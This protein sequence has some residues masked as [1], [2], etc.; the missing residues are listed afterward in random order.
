MV[1]HMVVV[2]RVPGVAHERFQ[3]VGEAE[4]EHG[5]V[6]RQHAVVV[7]VV[8]HQ[9]SEGARTPKGESRVEDAMDP[10]EVVEQVDCTREVDAHVQDDVCEEHDICRMADDACGELG[11][12][13]NNVLVNEG[14]DVF[15]VPGNDDCGLEFGV[16]GIVQGFQSIE[17]TIVGLEVFRVVVVG[18]EFLGFAGSI[19]SFGPS[20]ADILEQILQDYN[21]RLGEVGMYSRRHSCNGNVVSGKK[22][23][24][25]TG[26][27]RRPASRCRRPWGPGIPR[28]RGLMLEVPDSS[29]LLWPNSAK[30]HG[31]VKSNNFRDHLP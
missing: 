1:L 12:W 24:G 4:V 13:A 29:P 14:R 6:L 20:L 30:Y 28:T 3:N 27:F 22:R 15:L 21:V 31:F 26:G 10:R 23:T 25:C 7:D 19:R 11:V 16:F 2:V 17:R 5:P 8:V 18:I 9:E